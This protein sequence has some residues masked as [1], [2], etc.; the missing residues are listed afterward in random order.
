MAKFLGIDMSALAEAEHSAG[1]AG[2]TEHLPG[3]QLT[4]L[5]AGEVQGVLCADVLASVCPGLDLVEE[6]RGGSLQ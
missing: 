6:S 3:R 1:L 5:I 4:V 2:R